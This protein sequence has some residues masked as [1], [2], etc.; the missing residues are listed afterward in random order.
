MLIG[1]VGAI[2]S[3]KTTFANFITEQYDF[4]ENSFASPLKNLCKNL[5][6]LSDTQLYGSQQDKTTPDSRWYGCTPRT[7]MQYVGTELLRNQLETVMPG[8]GQNIFV[9]HMKLWYEDILSK[10]STARVVISDVRFEN[11]VQF[12]RRFGGIIVKI[13]V[14]SSSPTD[15]HNSEIL[16]TSLQD[17][18]YEIVNDGTIEEYY[19]NIKK[20]MSIICSISVSNEKL[21][22]S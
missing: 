14:T 11:E 13:S 16:C 18:D 12:I 3:G 1:V 15:Q 9:D 21:N 22:Q 5:F 7:M 10:N 19:E 17:Y 20:I 8:I 6:L 4:I 2:G